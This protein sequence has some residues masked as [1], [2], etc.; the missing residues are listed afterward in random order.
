MSFP[1]RPQRRPGIGMEFFPKPAPWH[2]LYFNF[3]SAYPWKIVGQYGKRYSWIRPKF[4]RWFISVVLS[5]ELGAI[6][7]IFTWDLF[8]LPI[9][10]SGSL[11]VLSRSPNGIH[12]QV[13]VWVMW[14]KLPQLPQIFLSSI[15]S[16]QKDFLSYSVA[17]MHTKHGWM[18]M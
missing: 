7:Y 6:K 5:G 2:C 9:V 10:E 8:A 13:L 3:S 12:L 16:P 15:L 18:A 11:W 17:K 1:V 14:V 4:A